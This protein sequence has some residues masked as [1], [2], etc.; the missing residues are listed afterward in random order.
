MDPTPLLGRC[1]TRRSSFVVGIGR[2]VMEIDI[3]GIDLAKNVFQLHGAGRSGRPVHRSKVSRGGLMEAVTRLCP[4]IVAME[5]CA[6]AHYW[7]R[8]FMATG[9]EVRL[10]SPQYVSPFVKTNKNNRNDAEAI[11]EAACRPTMRFVTVKSV[12]QED[13]LAVHRMR[14]ILVRQRTG[15]IN[16][17]RGLLGERG[18]VMPRTTQAF[19]RAIPDILANGSADLTPFVR[20]LVAQMIEHLLNLEAQI[21]NLE[22]AIKEFVRRSELCRKITAVAGVGLAQMWE[23]CC[24]RKNHGAIS[25]GFFDQTFLIDYRKLLV[26]PGR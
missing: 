14:G 2:F 7:A 10:I 17:V 1:D 12:E 13:I 9:I 26:T 16:Q 6:S 18:L 21:C 24:D 8:R 15:I 3:L 22:G 23:F 5:A 25:A 19:K 11:V 4:R 20:Q